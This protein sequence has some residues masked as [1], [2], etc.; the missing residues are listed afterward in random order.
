VGLSVIFINHNIHRRSMKKLLNPKNTYGCHSDKTVIRKLKTI[1]ALGEFHTAR[2]NIFQ[3]GINL[4]V[5]LLS[6]YYPLLR[7]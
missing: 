7:P 2:I 5:L 6:A 4:F 1:D 3:T